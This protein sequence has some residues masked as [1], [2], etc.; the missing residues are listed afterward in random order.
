MSS[1]ALKEMQ[2]LRELPVPPM[3]E[4]AVCYPGD[5]QYVAF[6]WSRSEHG[7]C[8]VD[9]QR[10][11]ICCSD[12]WNILMQ[13][14]FFRR[15]FS[16]VML[17]DESHEAIHWLL[18]NRVSRCFYVCKKEIVSYFL[19]GVDQSPVIEDQPVF[20]VNEFQELGE[21]IAGR[22]MAADKNTPCKIINLQKELND[23]KDWLSKV[24]SAHLVG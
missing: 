16:R 12:A 1:L 14:L 18:L 8:F 9:R 17:G 24:T 11:G 10:S 5:E 15:C 21:R 3:F 7:L 20:A 6:Y 13:H 4:R 23:L 19:R 2:C 22:L